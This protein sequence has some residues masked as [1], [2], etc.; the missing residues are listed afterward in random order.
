MS[1]ISW[2]SGTRSTFAVFGNPI[3]HSRS[4][5]IHAEFAR[6]IGLAIQYRA[7]RVELTDFDRATH[8][9]FA[10]GGSGLNITVPFKEQAYALAT[11]LSAR[12]ERAKACNTLASDGADIYGDTSDGIGLIR[13]MM[14]NHGWQVRERRV[15]LLGAGG[16]ARGALEPLLRE[17]PAALMIANRTAIK[18][19]RL[20]EEFADLGVITGGG[21]DQLDQEPPFDLIINATSAGLHGEMPTLSGE[22]LSERCCCYDMVY[23]AEPTIFMRWAA[24]NAAW[25]VSDGLGM[26]VEQAAEAF[27]IWHRERPDTASVISHLRGTIA[28]A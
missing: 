6:Q 25:A 7:I 22:I 8:D 28:A 18:A 27:Y 1:E 14:A 12:A 26:L 10:A 16:A 17:S 15:L 21:F 20:A 23:G 9:F 4:P 3:K 13:D 2:S 24:Q 11:R 19:Q 5:F